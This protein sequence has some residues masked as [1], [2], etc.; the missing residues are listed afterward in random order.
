MGLRAEDRAGRPPRA[1]L[2]RRWRWGQMRRW[3]ILAAGVAGL[4][5]AAG[6][7]VYASK[8][9]LLPPLVELLAPA[10]ETVVL[11]SAA[12]GMRVQEIFVEG[13]VE[14]AAAAVLSALAVKDGTPMLAVDVAAA[15]ARI[16]A[17][18]WI[19]TAA[20]ERRLPETIFVRLVERQ[21]LAV[22]QY[23]GRH[24]LIDRDG[25][26]I[27]GADV[28]RFGHLPLVVG[29]EADKQA[30]ALIGLLSVEPDLQ[31][32]VNAAVRV[33]ARRWTLR[34]DNGIDILLPEQNAGAAW[35][36]LAE[37]ER[38]HKV[39][40]RN[41]INIDLRLP[42]RMIVRTNSDSQPIRPIR[43]GASGRPT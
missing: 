42:D 16:E 43:R 25:A 6:G 2:R 21:P 41:V 12:L 29:A 26:E 22:W 3:L 5:G 8:Q 11:A 40:D 7:F 13:R 35:T 1:P 37:L 10:S 38:E 17:L 32:R 23:Q 34:L 27:A 15:K 33:G 36:R 20:V 4:G 28:A 30:A 19:K 39:L 31:K 14:T 24:R 18:P 9:G